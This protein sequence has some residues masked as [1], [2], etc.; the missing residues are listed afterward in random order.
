MRQETVDTT[1][2]EIHSRAAIEGHPIHPMVVVFPIAFLSGALLTDILFILSNEPFWAQA[3]YWLLLAGIVGGV[4]AAGFGAADFFMNDR[5]RS[6]RAAW[7]HAISNSITMALAIINLLLRHNNP[8]EGVMPWG[9]LLS[10]FIVAL[11]VVS[12][13]YGGELVYRH[14]VGINSHTH[15]TAHQD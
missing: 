10:A 7:I 3:S 4:V 8:V 5:I 13:W 6:I 15:E 9:V 11:L 12:G 1:H 2:L 14:K